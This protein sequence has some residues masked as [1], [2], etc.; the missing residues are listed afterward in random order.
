MLIFSAS[1]TGLF[2]AVVMHGVDMGR[3]RGGVERKKEG[4]SW[5]CV[6]NL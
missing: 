4:V 6:C 3:W 5:V 1:F 2:A